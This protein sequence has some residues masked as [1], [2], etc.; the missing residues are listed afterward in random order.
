VVIEWERRHR[1]AKIVDVVLAIRLDAQVVNLCPL[2]VVR[3]EE[4]DNFLDWVSE[5]AL[6]SAAGD[7]THDSDACEPG[8]RPGCSRTTPDSGI[9]IAMMDSVMYDRSRSKPSSWNL[10]FC[11]DTRWRASFVAM[12]P[13]SRPCP[14]RL[15]YRGCWTQRRLSG[16]SARDAALA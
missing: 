9:P 10:R 15:A 2:R 13:A 7:I 11:L 1:S 16:L 12:V 8:A 6:L 4:P 14:R 5:F 3:L